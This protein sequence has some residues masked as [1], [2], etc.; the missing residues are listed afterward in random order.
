MQRIMVIGGSGSGK[1]T[2]ARKIGAITGLPVIHVDRMY[3]K[4][5][6]VLRDAAETRSLVIAAAQRD[7]WVY[8]GNN[9]STFHQRAD[10]AHAIVFLDLP[11]W[12]RSFGI[13]WLTVASYGLSR[14]DMAEDCPERFDYGFMKW[15]LGYRKNGGRTRALELLDT[16]AFKR[17]I[18]H[19]RSRREV[20]AFLGVLQDRFQRDYA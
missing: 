4:A 20:N 8:D 6:W 9:S 5:G 2:L 18:F 13:V 11:T 7:E 10:R 16:Y 14:P 15:V 19:L 17:D 12:L 1:S 3:W